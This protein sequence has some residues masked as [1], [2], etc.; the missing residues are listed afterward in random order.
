MLTTFSRVPSKR[1]IENT[2]PT[3]DIGD[4]RDQYCFG[5]A[6]Q[7]LICRIHCLSTGAISGKCIIDAGKYICR[8]KY[9]RSP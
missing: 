2:A 3:S 7:D 1:M 8:C 5:Q 4:V 9:F 6:G